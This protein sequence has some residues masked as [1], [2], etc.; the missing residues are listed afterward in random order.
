MGQTNNHVLL[1]ESS[2]ESVA[3]STILPLS[4]DNNGVR[5]NL[6]MTLTVVLWKVPV[7]TV[8]MDT[9]T[10]RSTSLTW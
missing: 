10:I 4:V 6:C 2:A 7:D 9:A 1:S 3:N 5:T 8:T